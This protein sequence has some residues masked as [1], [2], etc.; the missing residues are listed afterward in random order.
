MGVLD[1]LLFRFLFKVKINQFP[2]LFVIGR[3]DRLWTSYE[4]MRNRYGR[5][6][7]G[8]LPQTYIVPEDKEEVK[9][10]METKKKAMI[11]KP[12]NFYCGIGI[13]LI[14]KPSK[15]IILSTAINFQ[16]L[17]DSVEF[18]HNINSQIPNSVQAKYPFKRG[19]ALE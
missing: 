1:K 9:S 2:G 11:V 3:K 17:L 18:R 15:F 12:P 10:I 7:F 14:S 8:F 13:R 16:N 5:E 4:K 19:A 6:N